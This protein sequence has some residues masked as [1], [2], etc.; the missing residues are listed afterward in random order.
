METLSTQALRDLLR[1]LCRTAQYCHYA[2]IDT[3]IEAAI[4]TIKGQDNARS[5]EPSN[6]AR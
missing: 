3:Y 1:A 2:E 5:K 4:K 6:V